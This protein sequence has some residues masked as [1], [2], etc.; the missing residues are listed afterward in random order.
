MKQHNNKF[1]KQQTKEQQIRDAII[2]HSKG[3]MQVIAGPGTGKTSALID[4]ATYLIQEKNVPTSAI[5]LVTYTQKAARELLTRLTEKLHGEHDLSG[6]YIGTFHHI[7]SMLLQ[8]Y[9]D[10]SF[11]NI[12]PDI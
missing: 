4:R 2:Q 12:S 1:N 3:P 11:F 5:M 6:M 9:G 8:K 7:C 10:R